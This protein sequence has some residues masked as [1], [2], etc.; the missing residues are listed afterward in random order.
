MVDP[1][2]KLKIEE[3]KAFTVHIKAVA[4][5][6]SSVIKMSGNVL[7]FLDCSVHNEADR[8]LKM[9]VYGKS[10]RIDQ[11]LLLYSLNP[12]QLMLGV[13]QTLNH[14]AQMAPLRDN[15]K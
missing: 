4:H 2:V 10:M 13:I 15:G 3:V 14:W 12:L 11:Y 5:K 1:W 8:S 9:E 7:V 6:S